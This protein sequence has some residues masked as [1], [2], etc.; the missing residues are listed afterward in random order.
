MTTL[1]TAF[2]QDV[3]LAEALAKADMEGACAFLTTPTAFSIARV[4][5]GTCEMPQGRVDLA[6]VY[7]ARVF[8]PRAELRW[9][10]TEGHA[11]VLTEEEGILPPSFSEHLPPMQAVATLPAR[12]LVWGHASSPRPG[13]VTLRSREVGAITLPSP[14]S[15]TDRVRLTAREYV[16]ADTDHGNAYVAEERLVGFEPYSPEGAA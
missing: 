16:V 13:W 1:Y 10:E 7:E 4:R 8:T 5:G 2:T 11:V 15:A 14:R 3:T 6:A 9:M 12:Y